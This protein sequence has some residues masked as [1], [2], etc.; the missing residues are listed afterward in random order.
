MDWKSA[1]EDSEWD[2]FYNFVHNNVHSI[3]MPDLNDWTPL[4]H[5]AW[6]GHS[7]MV[8][9]LIQRG[10]AVNLSRKSTG[11]TPVYLAAHRGYTDTVR[12]LIERKVDVNTPRKDG[13]TP[14][15]IAA[16]QGHTDTI[17]LLADL[18][19]D[20]NTP[21]KDGTTPVFIAAQQGHMDTIRLLAE[22]KADMNTPWGE[23]ETPLHIS[24]CKGHT[25]VVRYLV[26]KCHVRINT[27]AADGSTPISDAGTDEIAKYLEHHLVIR[28]RGVTNIILNNHI[29]P[30]CNDVC[31]IIL[32]YLSY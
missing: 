10:A 12:V 18:K 22:L 3:N 13:T 23:G 25:S 6:N 1:I 29:L 11:A 17:R 24:A 19:S 27:Q 2:K 16:Q 20:V 8:K 15:F 9:Y 28:V 4:Q 7:Q 32:K 31:K 21:R 30:F 26:E 14:V 5:A